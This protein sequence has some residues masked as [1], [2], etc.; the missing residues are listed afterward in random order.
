M[1]DK[2]ARKSRTGLY[3]FMTVVILLLLTGIIFMIHDIIALFY[4]IPVS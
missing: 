4:G 3:I 2:T 1:K